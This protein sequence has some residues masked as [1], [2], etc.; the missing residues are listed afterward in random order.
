MSRSFL[1]LVTVGETIN[2][3]QALIEGTAAQK[4]LI[5]YQRKL[6]QARDFQDLSTVSLGRIS[7]SYYYNFMKRHASII[8]SD[9]GCRFEVM[10]T[11]WLL[12]CKFLHMCDDIENIMI[13]AC[14]ASPLLSPLWMNDACSIVDSVNESFGCKVETSL[15]LPQCCIVMDEVGRDLNKYAK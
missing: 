6:F 10:R 15:N 11:K 5:D 4:K 2:L 9:K 12:Y 13:A 8:D 14:V 7:C 1:H 3:D